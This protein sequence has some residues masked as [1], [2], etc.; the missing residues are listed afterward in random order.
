VPVKRSHLRAAPM[1]EIAWNRP[2]HLH[3][4]ETQMLRA[5]LALCEGAE[6]CFTEYIRCCY[7]TLK[8]ISQVV[9]DTEI[10]EITDRLP[11]LL[12]LSVFT[13]R[14]YASA[15]YAV[16]VCPSVTSR[17]YVKTAKHRITQTTPHDST[18]S[19]VFCCQR[20][21]GVNYYVGAKCRW[22]GL[23]SATFDK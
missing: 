2:R 4:T 11:I 16:V 23:K 9:Q 17:Y 5:F 6:A 21:T 7:I 18:G 8:T 3:N 13:A 15:V 1:I 19:L 14:R 10:T 20:S 22:G 12:S